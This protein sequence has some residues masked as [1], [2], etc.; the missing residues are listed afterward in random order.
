MPTWRSMAPAFLLAFSVPG[1]PATG[2][3]WRT[4]AG[5]IAGGLLLQ[6]QVSPTRTS[7]KSISFMIGPNEKS[8]RWRRPNAHELSKQRRPPPFAPLTGWAESFLLSGLPVT[9]T[10]H[11]PLQLIHPVG[12][13]WPTERPGQN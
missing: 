7:A 13:N 12:A 2:T 4:D 8:E 11:L 1:I 10:L 6:A 3:Q 5:S 9:N